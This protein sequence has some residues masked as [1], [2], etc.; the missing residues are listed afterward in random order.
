MWIFCHVLLLSIHDVLSC[1]EKSVKSVK[2]NKLIFSSNWQKVHF[3]NHFG[4]YCTNFWQMRIFYKIECFGQFFQLLYLSNPPYGFCDKA[5]LKVGE[6]AGSK[7]G[8]TWLYRIFCYSRSLLL[9][10]C[11]FRQNI[12][13]SK[14]SYQIILRGPSG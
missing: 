6:T 8:H 10:L 13:L 7:V 4:P 2:S 11:T 1:W 9:Q 12:L 5:A 14:F 3:W